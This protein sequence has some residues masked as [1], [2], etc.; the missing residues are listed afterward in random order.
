MKT[1]N[2]LIIG[3][4]VVLG[5]LYLANKNK[6]SKADAQAV[7]D[8][9]AQ[10]QLPATDN[11]TS[12]VNTQALLTAQEATVF[13]TKTIADVNSLLVKYPP[14]KKDEFLVNYN[15][16][17]GTNLI[18]DSNGLTSIAVTSPIPPTIPTPVTTTLPPNTSGGFF[19]WGDLTQTIKPNLL[20]QNKAVIDADRL[21]NNMQTVYNHWKS[22][23]STVYSNLKDYFATLTKEQADVIIKYLPK[24]IVRTFMGDNDPRAI[25]NDF[26]TQEEIMG[27]VDNKLNEEDIL[28]KALGGFIANSRNLMGYDINQIQ[29]DLAHEI[30]LT[31][32]NATRPT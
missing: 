5:G 25:A 3:G 2:L 26:Y 23:F 31:N 15:T 29:I 14:L 8:T 6:K 27:A 20:V 1:T 4:A 17:N 11:S 10:A 21:F 28:N 7:I 9:Q 18:L 16:V 12:T 13:A 32:A 24:M 19:S 30:H 22:D